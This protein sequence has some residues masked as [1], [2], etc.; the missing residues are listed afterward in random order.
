[1]P[2]KCWHQH[3]KYKNEIFISKSL[4][5]QNFISIG[6]ILSKFNGVDKQTN[7]KQTNRNENNGN[8]EEVDQYIKYMLLR[9]VLTFTTSKV[10]FIIAAFDCL[11]QT[12]G[13]SSRIEVWQKLVSWYPFFAISFCLCKNCDN[14]KKWDFWHF[15]E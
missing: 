9:Y 10:F 2:R 7:N 6:Q 8:L 5:L 14:I 13:H 3:F 15:C 1:M 12:C 11:F 4:P